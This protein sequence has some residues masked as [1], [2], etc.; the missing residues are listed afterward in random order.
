MKTT[1]KGKSQ[2]LDGTWAGDTAGCEAGRSSRKTTGLKCYHGLASSRETRASNI[3]GALLV[4]AEHTE[5]KKHPP[6]GRERN[7]ATVSDTDLTE[8]LSCTFPHSDP[9][10]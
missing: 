6:E 2:E 9:L 3:Q 10:S 1:T 4:A 5:M 8:S 7:N